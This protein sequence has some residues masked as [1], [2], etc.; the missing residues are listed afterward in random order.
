MFLQF[1]TQLQEL[2]AAANNLD[3]LVAS[4]YFAYLPPVWGWV[5]LA[6]MRRREYV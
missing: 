3:R 2:R 1:Q 4:D 6:W 5:T